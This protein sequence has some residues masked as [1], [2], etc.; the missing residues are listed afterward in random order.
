MNATR[1]AKIHEEQLPPNMTY[2]SVQR[3]DRYTRYKFS[4]AAQTQ[5]GLGEFYTEESPHFTEGDCETSSVQ[6]NIWHKVGKRVVV[7]MLRS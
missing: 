1:G 7:M 3:F 5:A 4:V 6:C 2:F